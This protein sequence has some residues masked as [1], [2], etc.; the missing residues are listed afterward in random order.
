METY[1][2][3]LTRRSIRKFKDKPVP[4]DFVTRILEAAMH[5]P[6]AG[7]EEPWHFI[8]INDKQ[9]LEK[10]SLISES[11][12]YVNKAP[13]AIL[14][15]GDLNLE[16]YKG[17]WMQDCSAAVQ[18]MLLAAHDMGLGAVW[19]AVYPMEDRI[20]LFRK[21]LNFPINVV[22]LALVPI[23]YPDEPC[24]REERYDEERVHHN[25]W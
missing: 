3:I 24:I 19:T 11:A 16:E 1:E 18:N 12:K 20:R 22:P 23:G 21:L 2:C 7:D 15:C 4:K 6:S 5:A 13:M 25:Q 14:V 8:I 9:T 17:Y 10:V